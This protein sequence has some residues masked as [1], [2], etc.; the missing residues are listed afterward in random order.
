MTTTKAW[1]ANRTC[2]I[3]YLCIKPCGLNMLGHT[4]TDHIYIHIEK[5]EVRPLV[6]CLEKS[7]DSRQIWSSSC[8]H[9]IGILFDYASNT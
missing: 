7:L 3:I 1:F 4:R 2:G 5:Q 8:E 6:H 9:I